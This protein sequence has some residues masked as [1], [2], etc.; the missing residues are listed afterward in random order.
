MEAQTRR[1]LRQLTAA[2]EV[3]LVRANHNNANAVARHFFMTAHDQ[4]RRPR[5]E[6]GNASRWR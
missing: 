3:S 4:D 1:W 2:A 6:D 5:V